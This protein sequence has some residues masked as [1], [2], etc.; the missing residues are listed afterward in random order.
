MSKR[1][2]SVPKLYYFTCLYSQTM[3]TDC[4]HT[5]DLRILNFRNSQTINLCL[6]VQIKSKFYII[7]YLVNTRHSVLATIRCHRIEQFAGR[8]M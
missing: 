6:E 2:K 4:G 1:V 7:C 3:A 8:C 5:S